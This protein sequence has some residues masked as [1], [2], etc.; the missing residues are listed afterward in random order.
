MNTAYESEWT[1]Y[2][3]N[4]YQYVCRTVV[5]ARA[6]LPAAASQLK[7]VHVVLYTCEQLHLHVSMFSE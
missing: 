4:L 7:R 2:Q 6:I 3:A 1:N 5:Y